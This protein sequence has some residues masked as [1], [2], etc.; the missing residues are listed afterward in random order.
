[1]NYVVAQLD[2]PYGLINQSSEN[3]TSLKSEPIR[4]GT[5]VKAKI[6]GIESDNIISIPRK[7]I[8][9]ENKI[10]LLGKDKKLDITEIDILRT[11]SKNVYVSAGVDDGQQV[12]VTKLSTAINGMKLRLPGDPIEN[13]SKDKPSKVEEVDGMNDDES[14]MAGKESTDQESSKANTEKASVKED[15]LKDGGNL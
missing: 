15:K 14:M 12:I 3:G 5:F 8:R 4:M 7:A 2:D 13:Q 1:V 6:F 10:Y 9:G 11:D